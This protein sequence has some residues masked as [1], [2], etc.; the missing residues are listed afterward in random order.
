MLVTAIEVQGFRDLPSF[1]A[2]D[3]GRIVTVAGPTPAASALGDALELAFA[4]FHPAATTAMLRRWGA[5]GPGEE[6]E[7][8]GSPLPEQASW[9]SPLV[10]RWL[11]DSLESRHL[12]V[13][14]EIA[15]DPVQYGAL[16]ALTA[17]EPRLGSA[18]TRDARASVTIGAL[19]TNRFD[20]VAL[21]VQSFS[22]GGEAYPASPG[23]RPPWVS[24]LLREL[25][26]R[27]VRFRPE[28]DALPEEVLEAAIS[29]ERF[30]VYQRWQG[31]LAERLGTVRAARG[32]GGRAVLLADDLPLRR[33]GA[34]GLRLAALNAAVYLSG[35][36]LLWAEAPETWLDEAVEGDASPLE[37]VWRVCADGMLHP[38]LSAQRV[39]QAPLAGPHAF[40]PA[41]LGKA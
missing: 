3:L 33:H 4:A 6:A 37:Q 5:L 22:V 18:L 23:Q 38:E 29:A 24:A 39:E 12:T 2:A 19:F 9:S 20:A 30:D 1:R 32:P 27:F 17:R 16:R 34:A 28:S 21:A 10:G 25:G 13:A 11:V 26:G 15:L 41:P 40:E 31:A 14:L 8:V 36:D 7:I 35:A